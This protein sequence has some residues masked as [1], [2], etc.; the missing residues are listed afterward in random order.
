MYLHQKVHF[1]LFL[2]KSALKIVFL[3]KK[4]LLNFQFLLYSVEEKLWQRGAT[5]GRRRGIEAAAPRLA[6]AHL[7]GKPRGGGVD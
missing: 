5:S 4:M 2:S 6:G 7:W 3:W 1:Y